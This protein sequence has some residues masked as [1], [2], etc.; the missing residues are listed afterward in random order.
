[1]FISISLRVFLGSA[2]KFYLVFSLA[3]FDKS[4][5]LFSFDLLTLM[6]GESKGATTGE[7]GKEGL[8]EVI[9]VMR[10]GS[11]GHKYPVRIALL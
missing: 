9:F 6:T 8:S 3:S 2:A 10:P 7:E 1:M 5:W 4:I 11:F